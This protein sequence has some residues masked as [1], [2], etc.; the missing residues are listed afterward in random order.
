MGGLAKAPAF[1]GTPGFSSYIEQQEAQGQRELVE[2][3][4]LPVDTKGTDQ[5]F[6][7]LGFVFGEPHK[8]DPLFR[9]ATLPEGWRREG[10]DHSMGSY[11]VDDRGRKRVSIFYKAAFYDRSAHMYLLAPTYPL[12]GAIYADQDPTG[13]ELDEIL[14]ADIAHQYLSAERAREVDERELFDEGSSRYKRYA[15]RIRRIDQ[16]ISFLPDA[17]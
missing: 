6:V 15:E 4:D 1:P 7:N 16:L 8:Y 5:D 2:S 12:M 3:Q 17:V 11:I 13:I 10:S 9:P 14:T